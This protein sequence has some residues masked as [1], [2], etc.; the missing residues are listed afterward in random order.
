VELDLR[1]ILP[2]LTDLRNLHQAL[3]DIPVWKQFICW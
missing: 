3:V 1:D 2:D